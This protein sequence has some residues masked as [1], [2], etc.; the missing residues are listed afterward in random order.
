MATKSVDEQGVY[1]RLDA[2]PCCTNGNTCMKMNFSSGGGR[3]GSESTHK[4]SASVDTAKPMPLFPNLLDAIAA[5]TGSRAG[6]LVEGRVSM[7]RAPAIATGEAPRIRVDAYALQAPRRRAPPRVKSRAAVAPRE[8]RVRRRAG[9]EGPRTRQARSRELQGVARGTGVRTGAGGVRGGGTQGRGTVARIAAYKRVRSRHAYIRVRFSSRERRR[10]FRRARWSA[11]GTD[12]R[13][14][15]A[16][17]GAGVRCTGSRARGTCAGAAGGTAARDIGGRREAGE[18]QRE[19]QLSQHRKT[20]AGW[21]AAR[22]K[23]HV[24]MHAYSIRRRE[25]QQQP[26][27]RRMRSAAQ[28]RRINERRE[29]LNWQPRA[30][31]R[32]GGPAFDLRFPPA[33]REVPCSGP[34]EWIDT[35]GSTASTPATRFLDSRSVACRRKMKEDRKTLIKE[36]ECGVWESE[37]LEAIAR[38]E[39][40]QRVAAN[41]R[42]AK[43]GPRPTYFRLISQSAFRSLH[44]P[45]RVV[46]ICIY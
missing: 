37:L 38:V 23:A 41:A 26:R 15:G 35:S 7:Q 22:E 28:V 13:G 12:A 32:V 19:I 9:G 24:R 17:G 8:A 1:R 21:T 36:D 6:A 2:P 14:A 42:E 20:P 16:A 25:V 45:D 29:S 5:S 3:R 11:R 18:L 44:V 43:L 10:T 34:S 27:K 31:G 46:S 39:R 33:A 40:M 30:W 4:T